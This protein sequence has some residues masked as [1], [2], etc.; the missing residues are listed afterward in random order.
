MKRVEHPCDRVTQH[1]YESLVPVA[2]P[3][4]IQ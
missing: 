4:L 3:Y 1:F 2:Y